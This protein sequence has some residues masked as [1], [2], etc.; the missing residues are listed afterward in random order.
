MTGRKNKPRCKSSV[1]TTLR[2]RNHLMIGILGL[3]ASATMI[4]SRFCAYAQIGSRPSG[5]QAPGTRLIATARRSRTSVSEHQS[6]PAAESGAGATECGRGS[7]RPELRESRHRRY[8]RCR[9]Q[10]RTLSSFVARR[11]DRSSLDPI[12]SRN[13]LGD[14]YTRSGSIAAARER[15]PGP[16]AVPRAVSDHVAWTSRSLEDA[17][18]ALDRSR[19]GV[20]QPTSSR[21]AK[22]QESLQPF[23]LS[24]SNELERTAR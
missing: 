11:T 24:A 23:G 12:L 2:C 13:L 6:P 10:L 3:V 19:T 15:A 22:R 18:R 14:R 8:G 5:A 1:A 16:T 17:S 7:A 4:C 20:V 9:R 21:L